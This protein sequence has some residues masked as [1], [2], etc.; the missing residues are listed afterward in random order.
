[1]A[2]TQAVYSV[3]TAA[4]TVVAPTNDYAKYVLKNIQPKNVDEYARDGYMYT[5]GQQFTISSGGTANFSIATGAN[6][7]QLD[8]YTIIT[9]SGTLLSSLIEGG[10]VTTTGSAIQAYNLNRNYSDT[11]ASVLKAA[12]SITGG[13][14]I[15]QEFTTASVHAGGAMSSIKVHTLRANETYGMRFVN[16]GNQETRV[17]FQLG[18]S[19]HYNGYNNI[20]LETV[21]DSFVIRPSEELTMELPPLA[22]I[23]ATSTINSNK[24][25]VMRIE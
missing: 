22:T 1:M 5:L 11:H 10:T 25:S 24:L 3:G 14:A 21:N 17:F 16:Q 15:S 19:E 20:W 13:T 18:F 9:E 4:T 7:A 8:F 12:T 2:L 6:G 23:N